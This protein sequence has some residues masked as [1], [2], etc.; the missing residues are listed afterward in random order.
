MDIAY[1]SQD[2]LDL[3]AKAKRKG[4]V[5][6]LVRLSVF[7]VMAAAFIVG[8]TD[9]PLFLM[10]FLLSLAGFIYLILLFNQNRDETAFL[11]E[12]A[13]MEEEKVKR[14][15]RSLQGFDAG[16]EFIDKAHPFT[17]DLDIFGS[18][19]LFQLFNHTVNM[20]GK[21]KLASW[22]QSQMNP[23]LATQR[24]GAVRELSRQPKFVSDFE[25]TGRAFIKEEKSKAG[26]YTWLRQPGS[27]RSFYYLPLVLGPIGGSILLFL[28]AVGM[29]PPVW[30]GAWIVLGIF[31][32][33]LVFKPLQEASKVFP[34]QGDIK[35][36]GKWALMIEKSDFTDPYLNSLKEPIKNDSFVASEV[37]KSLEQ[38]AF[39]IQNRA[40]LM[41][42]IFN[43]VFWIDFFLI[44]RAEIWRKKFGKHIADWEEVFDT[45]QALV[46]LASFTYEEQNLSSPTWS[47]EKIIEAKNLRHPLIPKDKAVGND[48]SLAENTKT[49]LLTGSNM[50][51][52]TTFMRTLGINMVMVNVGLSPMAEAF[53]LGP[54]Q[55]FTSMRNA[56]NLG[57]SVSSFYAELARIKQLLSKAEAGGTVF[58]LLDE[59]LKGTNTADRIMGSEAL[60][61]Q[62]AAS[63]CKGIISTHDIELSQLD[64]SFSF[65]VNKSFHSEIMDDKIHFDYKLKPGPCPSFNAHKL[66]E[67]MGIKF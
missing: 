36:F 56:D 51:G 63:N 38:K 46:S 25:A 17:S 12:L 54:F 35:S 20:G 15:S 10:L 8:V 14:S 30:I 59:I 65:L 13:K 62:L 47:R 22:L 39:M 21:A 7:F 43:L 41:F 3:L 29:I 57:E 58:F 37:L 31:S 67:L 55:L 9:K 11:T 28:A 52:K 2:I 32:L 18:H 33:T 5:L 27:W 16:A 61:R 45:W 19:S 42:V 44:W 6:S 50:S 53:I 49:I 60:I 26:F 23:E 4:I 34:N 64:S 40:N 1:V 48:F 66:M 24:S